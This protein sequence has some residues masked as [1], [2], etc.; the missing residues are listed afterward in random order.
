MLNCMSC[1]RPVGT[2]FFLV[3]SARLMGQPYCTDVVE[4]NNEPEY[5]VE[6]NNE[7]E[8]LCADCVKAIRS[9]AGL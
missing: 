1:Y 5:V 8:Y 3:Q 4:S 7:P 6:S 2:E 9:L